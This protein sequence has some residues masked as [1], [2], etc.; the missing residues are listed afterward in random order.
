MK[1]IIFIFIA[2]IVTIFNMQAQQSGK[3]KFVEKL[4]D[5]VEIIK[6]EWLVDSVEYA[7]NP[8]CI[9]SWVNGAMFW[10]N[11]RE[12]AEADSLKLSKI[13]PRHIQPRICSICLR[14]EYLVEHVTKQKAESEYARLR[15]QT[16]LPDG[17]VLL[18]K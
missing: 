4:P 13:P 10:H 14:K 12:L 7:G 17:Q 2:S 11:E 3:P 9:H 15:R 8:Q 18:K 1:Q 5:S 6:T 16:R